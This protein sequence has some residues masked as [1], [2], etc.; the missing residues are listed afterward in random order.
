MSSKITVPSSVSLGSVIPITITRYT[1]NVLHN[2]YYRFGSGD[3]TTMATYVRTSYNFDTNLVRDHF[4]SRTSDALEIKCDTYN[5]ST[6]RVDGYTTATVIITASG[7]PTINS[8]T[9]TAINDNPVIQG[10]DTV[11]GNLFVQGYTKLKIDIDCTAPYGATIASS[12]IM[13]NGQTVGESASTS[14]TA[15]TPIMDSGSVTISVYVVDTRGN[16]TSGTKTINVYP[17]SR[18]Y[19]SVASAIRY[20]SN[21]NT[22]DKAG[23]NISAK[24]TIVSSS[25]NGNNVANVKVRYKQSGGVYPSSATQLTSGAANHVKINSAEISTDASYVVQFIIYDSLN[26]ESSNPTTLEVIVPTNAVT[27][28]SMDGG[29]GLGIG[30]YHTKE[31][32]IQLFLDTYL[33]GRLIF[34]STASYGVSDPPTSSARNGQVY[35]QLID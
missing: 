17:Y 10:W 7:T 4:A 2:L 3:Y 35:F 5:P 9:V 25:V 16:K 15:S 28:H 33:S 31:D 27:I 26:T 24:V 20:S 34:D 19:A 29:N 1:S 18:P 12:R 6:N 13:V 8:I 11:D 32:A 23:T 22:E 30:G 21:V 14:Y